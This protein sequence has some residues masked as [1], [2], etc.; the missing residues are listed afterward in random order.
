MMDASQRT[1]ATGPIFVRMLARAVD[2]ADGPSGPVLSERLG[3]WIDWTRAVALAR[4][5]DRPQSAHPASGA[6]FQAEAGECMRARQRL[7]D[8]IGNGDEWDAVL[9]RA[10]ASC[11]ETDAGADYAPFRKRYVTLQNAMQAATGRLRGRLRERLAQGGAD[12]AR[13][14][15]VDAVMEGVLSPREHTL[16]AKV[17]DLLGRCFQ[18]LCEEASRASGDAWLQAFPRDMQDMLLAELDV[19]FQPVDGLLAALRTH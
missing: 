8:A 10:L 14:A 17:P 3:Q 15:D 5:L 9:S 4:A 12:M 19:R 7:V 6:D 2:A 11:T 16:L 1:P 18:R 13:L